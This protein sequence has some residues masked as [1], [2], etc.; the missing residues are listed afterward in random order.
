LKHA[1]AIAGQRRQPIV[2][3]APFAAQRPHPPS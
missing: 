1:L 3:E 2:E